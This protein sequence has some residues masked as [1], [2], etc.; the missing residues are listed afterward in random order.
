MLQKKLKTESDVLEWYAPKPKGMHY[1]TYK[2]LI[3]EIHKLQAL[4]NDYFIS[5]ASKLIYR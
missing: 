2:S 5:K 1:N 3:N 4:Q